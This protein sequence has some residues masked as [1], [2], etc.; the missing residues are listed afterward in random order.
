MIER[1][2]E[3]ERKGQKEKESGGIGIGAR[4]VRACDTRAAPFALCVHGHRDLG[5][6]HGLFMNEPTLLDPE[7]CKPYVRRCICVSLVG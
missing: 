3:R 4:N 1:T 5:S 2:R 6:R 7:T